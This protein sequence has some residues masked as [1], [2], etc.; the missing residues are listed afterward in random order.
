MK[1]ELKIE[2]ILACKI[3]TVEEEALGESPNGGGEKKNQER[4]SLTQ[5]LESQEDQDMTRLLY[6]TRTQER[7]RGGLYNSSGKNM[8]EMSFNEVDKESKE[9]MNLDPISDFGASRC[10][11]CRDWWE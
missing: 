6:S 5:Y 11:K 9:I 7:R 4:E 2:I 1:N 10:I 8:N 3:H